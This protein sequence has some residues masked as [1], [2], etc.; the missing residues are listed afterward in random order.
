[1][2]DSHRLASIG[3][4]V[5]NTK[6]ISHGARKN[7][8]QRV[9]LSLCHRVLDGLLTVED[10]VDRRRVRRHELVAGRSA[11]KGQGVV[12][13]RQGHL[14]AGVDELVVTGVVDLVEDLLVGALVGGVGAGV[15][16]A[17]LGQRVLARLR[18]RDPGVG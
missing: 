2:N 14:H 12:L 6:P 13:Q 1:V 11:G 15:L 9:S 17:V 10:A 18:R 7:S 8:A 4:A 5:K 3:P 16:L